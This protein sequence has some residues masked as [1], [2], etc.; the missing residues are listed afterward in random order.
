MRVSEKGTRYDA[1]RINGQLVQRK[2]HRALRLFDE[3]YSYSDACNKGR[4]ARNVYVRGGSGVTRRPL[5]MPPT[6]GHPPSTTQTPTASRPTWSVSESCAWY[7]STFSCWSKGRD[8][9]KRRSFP[10]C[11]PCFPLPFPDIGR[12]PFRPSLR[13]FE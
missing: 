6:T 9:V 8:V 4:D 1:P 2:V 5:F 3:A 7:C 12:V 11:F 10:P 13:F